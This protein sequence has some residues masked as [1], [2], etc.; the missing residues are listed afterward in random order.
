VFDGTIGAWVPDL[1]LQVGQ[2]FWLQKQHAQD[3]IRIFTIN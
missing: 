1:S 2:G 3:W